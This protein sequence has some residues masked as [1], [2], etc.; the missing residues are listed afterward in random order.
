VA[1][2]GLVTKGNEAAIIAETATSRGVIRNMIGASPEA[3]LVNQ[4]LTSAARA[5]NTKVAAG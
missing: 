2:A 3:K 4:L 1:S 5:I